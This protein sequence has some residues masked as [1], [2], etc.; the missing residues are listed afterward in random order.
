VIAL[1]GV[2]GVLLS[3]YRIERERR[4]AQV[5]KVAEAAQAVWAALVMRRSCGV[6]AWYPAPAPTPHPSS[7]RPDYAARPSRG[8][9]RAGEWKDAILG[10]GSPGAA[11]RSGNASRFRA[12]GP[13]AAPVAL[14]VVWQ[15]RAR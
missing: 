10:E 15:G 2:V 14:T 9:N 5:T 1:M 4:L 7:I 3:R 11:S 12:C 8:P 13:R 6:G